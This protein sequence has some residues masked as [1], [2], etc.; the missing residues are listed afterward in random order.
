[1]KVASETPKVAIASCAP[2]KGAS[3]CFGWL[4]RR[5]PRPHANCR[6]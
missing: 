4:I 6:G 5:A 1:M 2:C 3:G